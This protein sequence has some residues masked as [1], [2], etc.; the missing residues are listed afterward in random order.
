MQYKGDWRNGV[1]HGT[2]IATM[3]LTGEGVYNGQWNRNHMHGTGSFEF[4]NGDSYQGD[5][6]FSKFHGQGTYTWGKTG[7]EY[8][9]QFVLGYRE[10][11]GTFSHKATGVKYIGLWFNDTRHGM[12]LELYENQDRFEG[13]WC[14]GK[15]HGQ[16]YFIQSIENVSKKKKEERSLLTKTH[17][18]YVIYEHMYENGIKISER[19]LLPTESVKDLNA[20]VPSG[21][22]PRLQITSPSEAFEK[23]D[24]NNIFV[25]YLIYGRDALPD[26]Q[27]DMPIEKAFILLDK[28]TALKRIE[29]KRSKLRNATKDLS[30]RRAALLEK[31]QKLEAVKRD[32]TKQEMGRALIDICNTDPPGDSMLEDIFR[33]KLSV[34]LSKLNEQMNAIDKM[35]ENETSQ[36]NTDGSTYDQVDSWTDENQK[37]YDEVSQLVKEQ[38]DAINKIEQSILD[39]ESGKSFD[40]K[41]KAFVQFDMVPL[42]GEVVVA[43]CQFLYIAQC[44]IR[45]SIIPSL[46]KGRD[47]AAELR[48]IME[49]L[50]HV[51]GER[52]TSI[53][54]K[55]LVSRMENVVKYADLFL[56]K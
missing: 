25:R 28:L 35:I 47:L 14:D 32:G 31:A 43:T 27:S 30:N 24:M 55:G 38:T 29:D 8:H 10:G 49:D 9:G 48:D 1:A 45:S 6:R 3:Q 23:A 26:Y 19:E 21:I 52:L 17:E 33:M 18:S 39:D 2:G 13:F 7:D 4:A 5:W 54:M 37:Q 36:S 15:R 42:F 50:R 53:D 46:A 41:S 34:Q 40:Y 16:G 12:G 20:H 56:G 51:N 44:F 22:L 11:Q